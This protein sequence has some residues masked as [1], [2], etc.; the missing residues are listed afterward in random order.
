MRLATDLP[1]QIINPP[2]CSGGIR[3]ILNG[4]SSFTSEM[5]ERRRLQRL[6]G[7]RRR[8]LSALVTRFTLRDAYHGL[9]D[10]FIVFK[11]GM[12]ISA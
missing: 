6:E 9:T 11:V 3:N 4:G 12:V 7:V 8:L 1:V 2:V 10:V 5:C